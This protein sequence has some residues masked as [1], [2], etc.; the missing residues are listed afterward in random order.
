MTD[1]YNYCSSAG[2]KLSQESHVH[3]AIWMENSLQLGNHSPHNATVSLEVLK[4]LRLATGV[5]GV[6]SLVWVGTVMIPCS[7]SSANHLLVSQARAL[8]LKGDCYLRREDFLLNIHLLWCNTWMKSKRWLNPTHTY[9]DILNPQLFLSGHDFTHPVNSTADPH[10]H[11]TC[12]R[13]FLNPERKSCGL[14]I[15]RIRVDGA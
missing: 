13:E 14:K 1:F 7:V 9:P 4:L 6:G 5:G 2:H 11:T 3:G 12:G 10:I 15:I 8:Y